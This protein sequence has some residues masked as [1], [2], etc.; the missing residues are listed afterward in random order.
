[1]N[2]IID[3]GTTHI[4][5]SIFKNYE[6]INI[7]KFKTSK[8]DRDKIDIDYIFNSITEELKK[9]LINEKSNIHIAFSN[10]MHTLIL[11]DEND[12][13]LTHSTNL[14]FSDYELYS[15]FEN[16]NNKSGMIF[17]KHLPIN[18]LNYL[19]ENKLVDPKLIN[20]IMSL[21]SYLI[22]KFTNIF[23]WELSD[24]SGSGLLD[25]KPQTWNLKYINQLGIN[26]NIFPEIVEANSKIKFTFFNK[27]VEICFGLSDGPA[28]GY[29]VGKCV[30]DSL[31]V[32][33]GTTFGVR[34]LKE[35]SKKVPKSN[36]FY[37]IPISKNES[38]IGI[39][40]NNGANNL[41]LL[42]KKFNLDINKLSEF[43]SSENDNDEFYFPNIVEERFDIGFKQLS[44]IDS[45][46][47]NKGIAKTMYSVFE[48]VCF[49][50]KYLIETT[51][52]ELGITT[53]KTIML[54]GGFLNF[55]NIEKFIANKLQRNICVIQN[56]DLSAYGVL[57]VQNENFIK[58]VDINKNIIIYNYNKD[59]RCEV[60]YIAWKN[61]IFIPKNN[62]RYTE[63]K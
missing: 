48:G 57:L 51:E 35:K 14:L 62:E 3:L 60:K 46:V 27:D 11:L 44:K 59:K 61:N 1:M 7:V 37:N 54:T 10:S 50:L 23:K 9:I 2:I 17:G 20:K 15:S 52:K 16:F 13:E 18:R 19:I 38:V 21:K 55:K 40:S 8:I 42:S 58:N 33:L 41:E 26:E 5:L 30:S 56:I 53:K 24:A 45:K 28:L 31:A 39:A 36:L 6:L 25:L 12:N 29:F 47:K 32:T 49:W 4:K 22:Y 43:T 63:T 34:I